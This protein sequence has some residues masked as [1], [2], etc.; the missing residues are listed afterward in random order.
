M[1]RVPESLRTLY[2]RWP[3][4][5]SLVSVSARNL[6]QT[7]EKGEGVEKGEIVEIA[8]VHAAF[9]QVAENMLG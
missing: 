6:T 7:A 4:L 3:A 5:V 1:A 8:N 9:M 2:V